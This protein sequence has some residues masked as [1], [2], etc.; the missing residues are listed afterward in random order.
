[1]TQLASDSKYRGA[2]HERDVSRKIHPDSQW[3]ESAA[4]REDLALPGWSVF[5][6]DW[7]GS[8]VKDLTA[9]RDGSWAPPA[10][11]PHLPL[12]Y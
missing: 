6:T 7:V 3:A 5:T 12:T 9:S 4:S 8:A 1:M 11:V 10:P 2:K